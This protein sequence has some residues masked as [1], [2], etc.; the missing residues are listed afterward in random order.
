MDSVSDI[1][2]FLGKQGERNQRYLI[3]DLKHDE[4]QYAVSVMKCEDVVTYSFET[5]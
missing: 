1:L 2:V 4:L 3:S 5:S